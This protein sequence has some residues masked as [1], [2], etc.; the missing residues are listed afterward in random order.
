MAITVRCAEV[1]TIAKAAAEAALEKLDLSATNR[2]F[3]GHW[4]SRWRGD[5]LP[6]LEDSDPGMIRELA[7]NLMVFDALPG[8]RVTVR[9]AGRDICTIVGAELTGI[10]W[11]LWARLRNRKLRLRNFDAIA[12]GAIMFTRR[13][14]TMASGPATFNQELVVP[15]AVDANGLQPIVAH[16]D[17]RIDRSRRANGIAEIESLAHDNRLLSIQSRKRRGM[18]RIR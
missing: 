8:Q 7:P 9:R 1:Q 3:A 11:I 10:D 16:T 6:R 4:L 15:F 12:D 5:E 14:L 17:W 13:R 18:P 2:A